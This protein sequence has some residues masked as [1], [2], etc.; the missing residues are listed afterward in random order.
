MKTTHLLATII[1]VLLSA[2]SG[3][4]N[5]N[6]TIFTPITY[7]FNPVGNAV[8]VENGSS[9]IDYLP[10]FINYPNDLAKY[11]LRGPVYSVDISSIPASKGD[12]WFTMY[13]DKNGNLEI[14]KWGMNENFRYGESY[15]LDY[16]ETG[17]LQDMY[18]TRSN[19]RNSDRYAYS[20]GKLIYRI[21]GDYY[22]K[23]DWGVNKSGETV[24]RKVT[25]YKRNPQYIQGLPAI[26]LTFTNSEQDYSDWEIDSLT[27]WIPFLYGMV[28]DKA[29]SKCLYTGPL[30]SS[31][32]T[33]YTLRKNMHKY[34]KL[35]GHSEFHYN[36]NNDLSS[37]EFVLRSDPN[38]MSKYIVKKSLYF[39]YQYDEY[40]NW[41]ER[42]ITGTDDDTPF[43]LNTYR[44]IIYYSKEDLA[45]IKREEQQMI[46]KPFKGYWQYEFHNEMDYDYYELYINFYDKD[47]EAFGRSNTLGFFRVS[48]TSPIVIGEMTTVDEITEANIKGN[49]AEIKYIC[50]RTDEIRSAKLVFNPKDKTITFVD[51]ELIEENTKLDFDPN[52]YPS[53]FEFNRL[54]PTKQKMFYVRRIPILQY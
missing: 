29:K 2:C 20:D 7:Y 25:T 54:E 45:S 39:Y 37:Y 3:D 49:E 16:T 1:I 51:G 11:G 28:T 4:N 9:M 26:D 35:Y 32:D 53:D 38:D 27:Y 30:L 19:H 42:K 10:D 23:Y 48:T 6:R 15:N 52:E 13:Y 24:P 12:G 40:G 36:E 31:M 21:R 8:S 17:Y 34:D 22:R 18:S 46:N 50:G 33:E 43:E 44:E 14:Q 5:N 47:I 41:T